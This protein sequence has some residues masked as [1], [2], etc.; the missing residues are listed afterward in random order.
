MAFVT[1]SQQYQRVRRQLGKQAWAMSQRT[2]LILGLMGRL[3]NLHIA[4]LKT[5]GWYSTEK[6]PTQGPA[7]A[8]GSVCAMPSLAH[9]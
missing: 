4:T 5:A 2:I 8:P 3:I 9:K 1:E 6:G 7:Q